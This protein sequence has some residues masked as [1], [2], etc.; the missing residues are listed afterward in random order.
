MIRSTLAL[1]AAL[2]DGRLTRLTSASVCGDTATPVPLFT[3]ASPKP[4][5]C[6]AVAPT[7][8]VLWWA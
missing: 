3:G 7:P 5:Q 6:F 1:I 4:G 2:N 8:V